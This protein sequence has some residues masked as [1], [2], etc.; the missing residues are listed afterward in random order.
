MTA[1]DETLHQPQIFQFVYI[2]S[3]NVPPTSYFWFTY[4]DADTEGQNKLIYSVKMQ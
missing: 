4:E 1:V 3:V 2:L